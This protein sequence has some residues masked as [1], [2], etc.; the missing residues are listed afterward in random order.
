MAEPLSVRRARGSAR[1][2]KGLRQAMHEG[3][4][5]LVEIPLEM[6]TEARAIVENAEQLEVFAIVPTE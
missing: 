3:L 2:L 4:G 5:G 1:F 6:A